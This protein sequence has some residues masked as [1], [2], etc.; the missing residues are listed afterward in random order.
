MGAKGTP[1]CTVVASEIENFCSYE[2]E[3]EMFLILD[4]TLDVLQKD[5]SVRLNAGEFCVVAR[6]NEHKVVPIGH[7]KLLLFEPAG[8]AHTG[9]VRS[10]ITR[11]H[12][13]R[14]KL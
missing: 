13:D 6:G 10:E 2:H 5:G 1:I 9:K 4:G 12:Y 11:D 7:A 8:I 14:L 3:D